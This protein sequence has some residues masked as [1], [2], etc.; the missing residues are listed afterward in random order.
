MADSFEE[1]TPEQQLFARVMFQNK[2]YESNGQQYENL[3][4]S[5]MSKRDER[6]RQV[7]PQGRRGDQGNDGFIPEEGRYFQVHAPEDPKDKATTAAKKAADDF[8]KLKKHWGA[9]GRIT[10]YRFVF[11]DKYQGVFPDIEHALAELKTAHSL[12]TCRPFVAKDLEREFMQLPASDIYAVMQAVIP[13]PEFIEDIDYGALSDILQHIV[14]NQ[15]SVSAEGLP[16]VPD[17]SE[18]IQ[19]N[20]IKAAAALLK[21]GN[22]QNAAVDTF[23]DQHGEFTRTDIRNRLA[24]SYEAAMLA[25]ENHSNDEMAAGDR[26]FFSLLDL[27]APDTEKQVQDAAIVLIAYFF[28]KC[29]VFQDPS[30]DS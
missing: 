19:F 29:D 15:Q 27:I 1:L 5:V 21:V 14:D 3:F 25:V 30:D 4:T 26:V 13:R 24:H 7:K 6:F 17:Y 8:E 20:E 23:F 18:K 2:V 16:D 9:N 12:E 11:N 28:E 22:F 10:D